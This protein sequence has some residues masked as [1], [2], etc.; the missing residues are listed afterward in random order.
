MKKIIACALFFHLVS[1]PAISQP[2]IYSLANVPEAIK[3]KASIIIHTENIQLVIENFEKTTF[4][5]HKI[6]TVL[7]EDGKH[8]LTF[9]EFSSKM[10]SL[11]EVEIKVFDSNGKVK[12]NIK[13]EI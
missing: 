4:K 7:N 13:K 3:N 2:G 6:F 10:I 1:H 9:K 11:E 8:A 5:V 12:E